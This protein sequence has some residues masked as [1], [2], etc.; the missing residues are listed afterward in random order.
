MEKLNQTR[1]ERKQNIVDSNQQSVTI[2]R[3]TSDLHPIHHSFLVLSLNSIRFG[4]IWL[5]SPNETPQANQSTTSNSWAEPHH[6]TTETKRE[7]TDTTIQLPLHTTSLRSESIR[8]VPATSISTL[9]LN[10]F[11]RRELS[12]STRQVQGEYGTTTATTTLST[13]FIHRS[14]DPSLGCMS[15]SRSRQT[16]V[17]LRSR[18][19]ASIRVTPTRR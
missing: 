16:V 3:Y 13:S 2:A 1:D 15:L 11:P 9:D 7:N 17:P 8:S 14:A 18:R 12:H 6:T 4:S 5:I 10:G 19:F